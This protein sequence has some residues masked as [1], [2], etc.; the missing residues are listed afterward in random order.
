[1]ALETLRHSTAHL[2]AAAINKIYHDAKFGIGPAIEDGFYY[3]IDIIL[4]E[5]D[6]KKIEEEMYILA[7]QNLKFEKEEIN[8]KRAKE[9]FKKQPYKL[10]L[11][12]E[13]RNEKI[14]IYSLG[15]FVDLCKGPHLEST[16]EIKYF[17]LLKLAGAYWKGDSKNK[18]LT[19]IYG[20]AFETKEELKNY[21]NL[22][23]EAKKRDHR[24]L[25][26]KLDLFSF[27]EEAPGFPFFHNKGLII[28]EELLKFWREEHKKAN[29]LEIK[30]PI[31]LNKQ[32]W[33]TSGHW[34]NYRENMYTLKIEKEDFAI[35]PM[36]CPG[37]MLVYKEKIHSYKE[38]PLRVGEIGL[39]H[40]HEL[41]GVLSGLFR[42]RAF[43]QDDAHIFMT[44]IQIK[45][46]I[47]N[48]LN[49]IDKFYS[50]FNL[51]YH[52]ELS[53]RPKKSIGTE[54][55]WN[56]A[57]KGLKDALDMIK[58]EYKINEG[59]GAFYGPKID[60]HV[61]D[62]LGRNWQC[63]TIQLDMNLPE[64][65]DLY[66][67]GPDGKKHRPVMIHRVVYGAIERFMG[68]IIE[69]YAGKFPVWL[70]PTQVVILTV[71]DKHKK[72]A[73]Q[74]KKELE[75]HNIRTELDERV[76]SIP[77]KVRDNQQQYIPFIIIVGD[78]EIETN[79]LAI[80]TRDNKIQ[81][82]TKEKFIKEI[83]EII[84]NKTC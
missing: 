73:N 3:D 60:I 22:I 66:Y 67:E 7:K 70:S 24:V 17:K 9:I 81:E 5:E 32:L 33:E 42:V 77:K 14:I 13:L 21:L 10:E 6:F 82:Y 30:T 18:M 20:T 61:K 41:S 34:E 75:R 48:V 56:T 68:I 1:M 38:F 58:K 19:R 55:A 63:G 57:I 29:Y 69:H 45:D 51:S 76:E 50:T 44:E 49:L 26:K 15:S 74:L 31:L 71:S 36:N 8:Y 80:R 35:K 59:E 27:H 28:W 2:M 25:G 62:A 54:Q 47:I 64:R 53:T 52:L 78:K 23:E 39:V 79:N 65:F 11:I 83:L 46:E 72:Y 37:G 84:K 4:H 12:E 43:H 40:R 16:K